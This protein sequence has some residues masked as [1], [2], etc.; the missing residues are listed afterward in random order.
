MSRAALLVAES[1]V[2]ASAT[3]AESGSMVGIDEM[4][5]QFDRVLACE[6]ALQSLSVFEYAVPR[7][8]VGVI[9]GNERNGIPRKLL[10]KADQV[11]SIPMLGKGLSSATTTSNK[12]DIRRRLTRRFLRGSPICRPE[13][14]LPTTI[15]PTCKWSWNSHAKA[16]R[17]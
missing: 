7:G 13:L 6:T 15:S 11:I 2:P 10:K 9:V 12:A 8:H 16:A 3:G 1:K 17:K 14:S 4:L 5:G